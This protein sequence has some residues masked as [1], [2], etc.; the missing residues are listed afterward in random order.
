MEQIW[1]VVPEALMVESSL[2]EASSLKKQPG[3]SGAFGD[4]T[5]CVW[6]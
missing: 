6:G 4:R 1:A 5:T 2:R 3:I